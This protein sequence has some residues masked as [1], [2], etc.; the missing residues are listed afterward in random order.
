MKTDNEKMGTRQ[1]L[2]AA[3]T[4]LIRRK[5]LHGVGLSD[6]LAEARAP[7]GVLYHHFPG[8]KTELAIVAIQTAVHDIV[9]TLGKL[10]NSNEDPSQM[11]R[12]WWDRARKGLEKSGFEQGCPLAAVALESTGEDKALRQVLSEGFSAIRAEI[13]AILTKA[14]MRF[15]KAE[16]FSILIVAAYE[17][18]LLQSRIDTSARP[19]METSN[20][21]LELMQIELDRTKGGG[22]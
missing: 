22:K 6:V 1:R 19:A 5:G 16:R 18:A 10:R 11:L 3:M 21:L 14:G 13:I 17:G 12:T 2:I 20:V 15:E 7:K 4:D 8:G 9:S